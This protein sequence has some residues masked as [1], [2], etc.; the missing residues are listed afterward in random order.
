MKPNEIIERLEQ[1]KDMLWKLEVNE[2]QEELVETINSIFD[3]TIETIKKR[4]GE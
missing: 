2:H 1:I 3:E 4:E